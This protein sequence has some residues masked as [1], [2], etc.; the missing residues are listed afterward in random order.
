MLIRQAVRFGSQ[1]VTAA[2]VPFEAQRRRYELLTGLARPPRGTSVV[3][4]TVAGVPCERVTARHADPGRVV[5]HLHGG[6]FCIGSPRTHRSF[7]GWLSRATGASVVLPAYRLAP[8]HPHPAGREDA[9]AAWQSLAPSAIGLCGDSA[10]GHLAIEVAL[11][12][13]D[14]GGP[15]PPALALISPAI[16]LGADRRAEPDLVRRD[17]MIPPDWVDRCES[18][19]AAAAAVRNL[20]AADLTGLPRTLVIAGTDE[21][22]L[23]DADQFS[24]AARACGVDVTDVRGERMWHDYP[25]VA[26]VC[27]EADEAVDAISR[28]L[29]GH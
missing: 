20:A 18:A 10:G 11:R 16:H 17:Q 3:P 21:L 23:R 8:E 7:A 6:G 12:M 9:T 28:F 26:G 1:P 24:G 25:T 13:R 15:M 4:E 22:L 19:Y 2:G 27:R 29:A 14:A 5:V